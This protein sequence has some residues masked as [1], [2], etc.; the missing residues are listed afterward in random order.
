MTLAARYFRWQSR[1]AEA[2]LGPR[3][4]E[5][6]CGLGNFTSWLL[7]RRLVVAVDV[8]PQCVEI[9]RERFAGADNL[10]ALETSVESKSFLDLAKHDVDSIVCLNVLEHIENDQVALHN[11]HAVLPDGGKVVLLVP[12]FESLYGPIDRNL[13]HYRRYSKKSLTAVAASA[14]FQPVKLRYMNSIG[15]VG[16]WLNAHVLKKTEQSELQIRVFDRVLVPVLSAV[17][18]L[19]EPPFGQSIFAVF[20]KSG[21]GW[22]R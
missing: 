6:G 22:K 21:N 10:I 2:E 4:L 19:V 13:G 20:R 8:E 1:L 12:A 17:E 3:V 7:N 18:G 15:C 5:V 14:G 11:M 16:W 9:L